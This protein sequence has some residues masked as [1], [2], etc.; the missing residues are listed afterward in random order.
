MRF[1]ISTV[2]ALMIL[3]LAAFGV[4]SAQRMSTASSQV[5]G[6]DS[7]AAPAPQAPPA[8]ARRQPINPVSQVA[9]IGAEL[10]RLPPHPCGWR[11][12]IRGRP[13][14][15]RTRQRRKP[16]HRQGPRPRPQPFRSATNPA[17]WG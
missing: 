2:A 4:V 8:A 9:Q 17:A 13:R 10:R 6:S 12:R 11:R 1:V 16:Q 15:H 14:P 5:S 3:G 7:R